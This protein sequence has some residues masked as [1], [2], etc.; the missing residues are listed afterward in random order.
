MRRIGSPPRNLWQTMYHD[1]AI[2]LIR[3]GAD[4]SF[5]DSTGRSLLQTAQENQDDEVVKELKEHGA[6]E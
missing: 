4:A 3:H 6:K 2:E 5:K 1:I